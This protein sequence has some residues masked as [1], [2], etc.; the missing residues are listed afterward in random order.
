MTTLF[1]RDEIQHATGAMVAKVCNEFTDEQLKSLAV[2]GVLKGGVPL[3]CVVAEHLGKELRR[4][5]S[6][7][8]LD[9]SLYRDDAGAPGAIPRLH[10]SQI[11]FDVND[12]AILL[13]DDVLHTGRT[14]RAAMDHLMDFGRPSRIALLVLVDRGGRQ[15]PI[16]ADFA[17]FTTEPQTGARI[18]VVFERNVPIAVQ[19]SV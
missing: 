1:N 6:V 7:G 8:E 2:V 17:G 16:R 19:S 5:V 18:H 10:G 13:V 3:G 14:I 9:I 15:L 11:D 12:R 4:K